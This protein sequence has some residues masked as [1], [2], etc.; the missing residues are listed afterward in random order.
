MGQGFIETVLAG[1]RREPTLIVEQGTEAE[2]LYAL[3]P[4]TGE[5]RL[6]LSRQGSGAIQALCRMEDGNVLAA[7]CKAPAS[8]EPYGAWTGWRFDQDEDRY[9]FAGD[10][11]ECFTLCCISLQ[12]GEV[13]WE[14]KSSC[15]QRL[16]VRLLADLQIN[17]RRAC[18]FCAGTRAEVFA[19]D[20]GKA[21][22]PLTSRP[23]LPAFWRET[24][25]R[26]R[27]LRRS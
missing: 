8:Q 18:V 3:D 4:A 9:Y 2:R 21:C 17:E 14:E 6:L 20:T 19:Q 12:T 26:R 10:G 11:K 22:I 25:R 13:L 1:G 23:S 5:E 16:D 27:C 24:H 15:T 7:V